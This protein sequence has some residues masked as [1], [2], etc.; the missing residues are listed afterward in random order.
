MM[1]RCLFAFALLLMF[2]SFAFA[3]WADTVS[4]AVENEWIHG[5]WQTL[6]V[7]AL[8]ISFFIVVL[9]YMVSIIIGSSDLKKWAKSEM[10]QVAASAALVLGLIIFVNILLA[11]A[12]SI[13]VA[14]ASPA[15]MTVPP[16]LTDPTDTLTYIEAP[17]GAQLSS[18]FILAHYYLNV[19]INCAKKYYRTIFWTNLVLEPIEKGVLPTGGMEEVSG[20]AVSGI[21]GMLHWI[22]HQLT[23]VLIADYFQRHLLLFIEDNMFTIILPI[24]ILLRV[25]PYTRGA[26]GVVIAVAIGTFL[27]FPVMYAVLLSLLPPSFCSSSSV[28][29]VR[30]EA[31]DP[32]AIALSTMFL[33][34]QVPDVVSFING[35]LLD[36][37]MIFIST[38]VFPVINLMITLTFIRSTMQF[39]GADVAEMG[40][41]LLKLI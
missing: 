16:G 25:F 36:I 26:G 11:N 2:S 13:V 9:A 7:L 32:V 17:S 38:F 14:I 31:N 23:F 8:F 41:G 29:V 4:S 34:T 15:V 10:L 5:N 35:I 30:Y 3:Q 1:K 22:E 39:L 37:H 28:D 21:A 24:G 40:H 20:W 6:S 12:S 33:S 19:Q 18:P 27:V